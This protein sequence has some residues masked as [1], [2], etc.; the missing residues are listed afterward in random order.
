MDGTTLQDDKNISAKNMQVLRAAQARG[1]LIVPA[2]GRPKKL[3]PEAI[4]NVGGI[5]YCV[6]SNGASVYDYQQNKLI[7]SNMMTQEESEK[8]I[9]FLSSNNLF[10]E[11]YSGG[12]SYTDIKS[13]ALLSGFKN[14]PKVYM[15]F[16]LEAQTFVE[17]L[18]AFLK[19]ENMQVEK[20][21]IP[22]IEPEQCVGVLEQLREMKEYTLTSSFFNNIEINHAGTS[23]GDALSHLCN[24]LGIRP[25]QVMAIGDG[26]NDM[27]MLKFAGCGVAMKNGIDR[28][29]SIADYIT[30]SNE[31][32]G[33]A[34]A[35]E[36]LID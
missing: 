36:R 17:D 18:P 23:K 9:Q 30:L 26:D 7:Y 11:A 4:F 14:F 3:I 32:D 28:L 12:E 13:K 15:D 6:T 1:I 22:Y 10:V 29:K 34:Y 35:I 16:I 25:E 31:E 21:N 27:E 24:R 20:I 2:T 5:R 33:V 19:R 8:L